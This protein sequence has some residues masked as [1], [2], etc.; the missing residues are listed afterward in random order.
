MTFEMQAV[1][2]RQGA[3]LQDLCREGLESSDLYDKA[4][5]VVILY[6]LGMPSNQVA[7]EAVA[8]LLAGEVYHLEDLCLDWAAT[9]DLDERES[10]EQYGLATLDF[11]EREVREM[12]ALTDPT[13]WESRVLHVLHAR[14]S[15]EGLCAMLEHV[16]A[17]TLLRANLRAVDT[18][19][20]GVPK[21]LL[22]TVT[23]EDPWLCRAGLGDMEC[24]WLDWYPVPSYL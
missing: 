19:G 18:L 21:S 15:L 17:G 4:T 23:G 20:K 24:W 7:R 1:L 22:R 9:L 8:A 16:K 5:A 3:W 10:L 6:R 2:E 13:G 14:D 11:V 12:L